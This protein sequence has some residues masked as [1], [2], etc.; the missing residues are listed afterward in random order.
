ML[1]GLMVSKDLVVSG[2]DGGLAKGSGPPPASEEAP[3][4]GSPSLEAERWMPT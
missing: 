1:A 2:L 3:G 4:L